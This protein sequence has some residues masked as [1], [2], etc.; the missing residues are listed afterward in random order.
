MTE[1]EWLVAAAEIAGAADRDG[2]NVDLQRQLLFGL[3]FL[4]IRSPSSVLRQYELLDAAVLTDAASALAEKLGRGESLD[5]PGASP[6]LES[7]VRFSASLL[8]GLEKA[9]IG[10]GE[11]TRA[12]R[13]SKELLVE[14][15]GDRG[16]IIPYKPLFR[17]L[18]TSQWYFARRG[19]SQL[20][21]L[22]E[23]LIT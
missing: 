14:Y 1:E 3:W 13:S 6:S 2:E 10:L 11:F 17:P 4:F 16:Y 9:L 15:R 19:L 8:R 18:P 12:P 23:R 21:C 5:I 7:M 22:P 20:R